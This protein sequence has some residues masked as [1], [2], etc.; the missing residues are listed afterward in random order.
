[1]RAIRLPN[2]N[3]LPVPVEP[4]DLAEGQGL[5]ETGPEHPDYGKWLI[6]AEDGEDPRPREREP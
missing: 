5:A 6:F 1:M 2:G 3:L 4:N